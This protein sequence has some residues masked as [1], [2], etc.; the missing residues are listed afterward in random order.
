[1]WCCGPQVKY[2]STWDGTLLEVHI[3]W[4]YDDVRPIDWDNITGTFPLVPE[5][6]AQLVIYNTTERRDYSWVN[7]GYNYS[8]WEKISINASTEVR[9]CLSLTFRCL[10]TAFPGLLTVFSLPLGPGL[11]HVL[12]P[13]LPRLRLHL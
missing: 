12:L 4:P 7:C 3:G 5:I 2:C 11:V 8:I 13:G 10:F 9:H 1:M 6:D